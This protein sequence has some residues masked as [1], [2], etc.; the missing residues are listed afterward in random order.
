METKHVDNGNRDAGQQNAAGIHE[1]ATQVPPV[2]S[3]VHSRSETAGNELASTP[4]DP[5]VTL[6]FSVRGQG[7]RIAP[8]VSNAGDIELRLLFGPGVVLNERYVLEQELGHGGMGIVY[9]GRD[10]RLDRAVAVKAMLPPD[11]GESRHVSEQLQRMFADEARLGAK[12]LHP[13]I[14][15]VFDYGFHAGKPFIVFEY[16]AGETLRDVLRRRGRISLEEVRLVLPAL[17]QA[18]D[19]AHAHQMVH[20]DLKPENIRVTDQGQYKILDLGLATEFGRQSDWRFAGTPAYASPEQA[21]EQP[22]DGRTDQYALALIVYEML[23]GKRPF[24]A[25]EPWLLLEQHRSVEPTWIAENL[26]PDAPESVRKALERA[27]RKA[28]NERYSNCAEFAVA[29]GCQLLNVPVTFSKILRESDVERMSG[30]WYD[31][32]FGFGVKNPVHLVLAADA[33]WS[34]YHTEVSRFPLSS[35]QDVRPRVSPAPDGPSTEQE[36]H[37]SLRVA[38]RNHEST[39][40]SIGLFYY[41]LLIGVV[42]FILG[43]A[44][45]LFLSHTHRAVL[46]LLGSLAAT[47]LS[48]SL[49]RGLRRLRSWA[50]WTAAL[51]FFAVFL[52]AAYWL[53]IALPGSSSTP[54]A[55]GALAASS[56]FLALFAY[57]VFVLASRKSGV[58]CSEKYRKAVAATPYLASAGVLARSKNRTLRLHMRVGDRSSWRSFRFRS[59]EE[60]KQWA[61]HLQ[62]LLENRE[63]SVQ[64]CE[65]VVE[66][67]PIV[68]MGKAPRMHYQLLGAIEARGIK[69]RFAESGILVRG[70][71]LGA[72]AVV[73]VV[74]ER[75]PEFGR[76]IHRLSGNAVRAVDRPGQVEF[77]SRWYADRIGKSASL[78]FIVLAISLVLSSASSAFLSLGSLDPSLRQA[79]AQTLAASAIFIFLIHLWPFIVVSLLWSSRWPELVGSAVLAILAVGG[80]QLFAIAGGLAGAVSSGRW[81]GAVFSLLSLFD[82]FGL[83]ILFFSLFLARVAWRSY[84]DYRR[85]LPDSEGNRA[86][87]RRLG[88]HLATAGSV[89]FTIGLATFSVFGGTQLATRISFPGFEPMSN[90]DTKNPSAN[91][92]EFR[93]SPL[94]LPSCTSQEV[95]KTLEQI[96]RGTPLGSSALT[97]DG[98]REI[99]Y[100]AARGRREGQCT[101]H[102]REE[103]TTVHFSVEWLDRAKG[104]FIVRI[105]RKLPACGSEAVLKIV[106]QL[107]RGTAIGPRVTSID[108]HREVSYDA[109]LDRREG[110]CVA[111]T[112][113]KE[114]RFAYVVHWLDRDSGRFAVQ[115]D[116]R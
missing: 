22:S 89:I 88:G 93:I 13:A 108:A 54:S 61:G 9:R 17:A 16:I 87:W 102:R 112:E 58:V 14:A 30:A 92:F 35:I 100:D 15:T 113:E 45:D 70:A 114:I 83:V 27:L 24:S 85:L 53:V 60:C 76:T 40:R 21:A 28:P 41:L 10:N 64:E 59:G 5:C 7:G 43:F 109:V 8:P 115:L 99:S 6:S 2:Q 51:V 101:I 71:M 20:R 18:L 26:P 90:A 39:I 81:A 49:G 106:E 46:P 3:E 29:L 73:D 84:R 52:Y 80:R 57:F 19:F 44:L 96:L 1:A 79:F 110:E 65:P 66:R 37:E 68:L 23:T 62:A 111:H 63:S 55:W 105:R 72:D 36:R 56:P 48:T 74:Q 97:I 33:I 12:L 103:V 32:R 31:K 82:P 86:S 78:M 25:A 67:F 47:I 69:R 104:Q 95:V 34:R 98:H 91:P 94:E 11:W 4:P 107:I 42:P 75:L 38:F 77:R 116:Q 50:R